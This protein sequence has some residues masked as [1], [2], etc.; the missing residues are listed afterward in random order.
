MISGSVCSFLPD[1]PLM[2]L[3]L[4]LFLDSTLAGSS[5]F[6]AVPRNLVYV[7]QLVLELY[8]TQKLSTSKTALDAAMQTECKGKK[9]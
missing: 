8:L 3:L 9:A 6:Y 1:Y 4:F 5:E 2:F 7:R